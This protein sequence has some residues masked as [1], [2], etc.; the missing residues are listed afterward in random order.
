[1]G[2]ASEK[3]LGKAIQEASDLVGNAARPDGAKFT[4]HSGKRSLATAMDRSN[5]SRT[6]IQKQLKHKHLSTTAQ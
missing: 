6:E 4:S 5:V 1:M 3:L 2:E